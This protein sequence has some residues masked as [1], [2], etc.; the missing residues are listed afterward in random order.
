M[1]S[2]EAFSVMKCGAVTGT[3]LGNSS[4][5]SSENLED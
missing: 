2:V 3:D 1:I 5:D 4:K